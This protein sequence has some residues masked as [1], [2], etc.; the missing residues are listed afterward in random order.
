MIGIPKRSLAP[1]VYMTRWGLTDVYVVSD[2]STK[3]SYIDSK[4]QRYRGVC[5][6]EYQRDV[7]PRLIEDG[8]ALF[9]KAG[10]YEGSWVFQQDGARIHTTEAS[11]REA[12]R[13]PGGVLFPWPANSPDLKS[14]ENIWAIMAR[15]IREQPVAS[16]VDA[17]VKLIK[18]AQAAVP[19]GMLRN[20]YS[21]MPRRLREVTT[22]NGAAL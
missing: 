13:A 3:S 9:A 15:W 4:G 21:S 2:G 19:S 5:A 17:F 11:L 18:R 6:L 22:R 7:L 8:N 10:R 20:C 16:D 12:G 14:I 1:H